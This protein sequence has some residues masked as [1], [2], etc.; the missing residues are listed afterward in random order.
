MHDLRTFVRR[1]MASSARSQRPLLAMLVLVLMGTLGVSGFVNGGIA[2]YVDNVQDESALNTIE[3]STAFGDGERAVDP[4]AMDEI[5]SIDGVE[6]VHPWFQSDLALAED[7][8]PGEATHPGPIWATPHIPGRE[9]DIIEGAMPEDGLD[10]G[11]I[12]VPH[13][14]PGGTLDSLVGDTVT[15]QFTEITGEGQGEARDIELTVIATHDNSVPGRDGTTPGYL[16]FAF[17]VEL[18]DERGAADD[19]GTYD[20][21]FVYVTD[22]DNVP[23]VQSELADLGFGVQS[24]M[25]QVPG[26]DGLFSVLSGLTW[27]MLAVM[28]ILS[29][30]LGSTIGASWAK[31]RRRDIGLLK[32]IGW[33]GSRIARALGLEFI[34]LGIWV[35]VVGTALGIAASLTVT[36]VASMM[37]TGIPVNAWT[38]PDW[39]L[40][41]VGLIIMPICLLLGGLP[42]ALRAA[43]VDADVALR[44][45]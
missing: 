13:D 31:N 44:G 14:V 35:G 34:A 29:L 37:T 21:A 12:I 43:R 40:V 5:E 39:W 28:V 19:S 11:E 27:A 4:A 10:P 7:Y 41:G 33:N 16:E 1:D 23:A 20:I 30:I 38:L 2:H 3:I 9:I 18:Q 15:L 22:S 8:W 32:A 45:L 25:D 42:Q 17:L 36:A 26:L 6:S 24:M